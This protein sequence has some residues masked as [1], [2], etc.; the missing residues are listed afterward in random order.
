MRKP[1]VTALLAASVVCSPLAF[2]ATSTPATSS[3]A[4]TAASHQDHRDMHR[5]QHGMDHRQMGM[6]V[7]HQLDLT[8]AQRTSIRQ[9]MQQSMEQ[10]RPSMM[11]LRDKRMAFMGATPGTSG[12][13][14][15]AT[16]LAQ[17]ESDAARAEVMREADLRTKIYGTLTAEQRTK[18]ATLTTQR[19]QQ[20][21]QRRE[22][23]KQRSSKQ[24]PAPAS[25]AA[26]R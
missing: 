15:A 21:Q 16:A 10:A 8:D 4:A 2:A 1:L 19:M 25:T 23:W 17:A 7:L 9:M 24:A 5:G 26:P 22:A 20:M 6:G 12:Y 11:A 3:T 18:L 13:Q 14:A